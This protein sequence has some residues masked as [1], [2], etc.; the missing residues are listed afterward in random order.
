MRAYA[1]L[2]ALGLTVGYGYAAQVAVASVGTPPAE[3]A[4]LPSA[5][6]DW[7]WYGGIMDPI[8]VEARGDTPA[9]TQAARRLLFDRSNA[10]CSRPGV[11]HR[12]A[13][14]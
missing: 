2:L 11:A 13:L 12:A 14:L 3:P 4:P 9:R 7:V 1:M 10:P 6:R 8:T 5:T